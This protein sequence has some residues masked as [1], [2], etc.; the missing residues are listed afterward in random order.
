MAARIS[1][2]EVG[3]CE[4]FG[5]PYRNIES[6]AVTKVAAAYPNE[7][8]VRVKGVVIV[9]VNIDRR[10]NVTSARAICG[11]PLLLGA[12][13]A[14]ARRWKFKP[15]RL[16]GRRFPTAGIISFRFAPPEAPT[17]VGGA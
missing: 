12:S 15:F 10:G 6:Q 11:H 1:G 17:K 5:T 7:P 4:G 2:H 9:L 3:P 16:G 8:G 13:V 14:A